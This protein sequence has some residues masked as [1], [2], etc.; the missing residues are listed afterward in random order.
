MTT[1]TCPQ[2]SMNSVA[3]LRAAL[4]RLSQAG[5]DGRMLRRRS[6]LR[7]LEAA[8]SVTSRRSRTAH[9]QPPARRQQRRP[10]DHLADAR[11]AR[12][13]Q[14]ARRR[15][16]GARAGA[17]RAALRASAPSAHRAGRRD[18]A[19]RARG[20]DRGRVRAA[21]RASPRDER[22]VWMPSRRRLEWPNGAVAQAFSAEDPE[23]LRGPQF[24]AAWC[25]ELAKWRHAE[26]TFDMLQF[27]LR[28][29][30]RPRQVITTTPRP[31]ALIKRLIADPRTRG[32]ARGDARRTPRISRRRSST[33]VV[34]ALCRHAARPPGARRRD[35]RG[36]RRRAVVA[37]AD[38]G[39]PRR[40]RRRRSR[41]S[42]S[43][44]DPP[45]SSRQGADACGIVAAGRAED[46]TIYVLA[47]A[48]AAGL[49]PAGWA[50]KAIAL[51]RQARGRRAGRR[52]QPGRRHGA[53]G[54]RARSTRACR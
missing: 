54:D 9:Q 23:S 52:G 14:D 10:V 41:A 53:R 22:P 32:D 3:T 25:D 13:R 39:V 18:R 11:R 33:Q 29:G 38:R 5:L 44:V 51:Y 19:R 47:D 16:M 4:T 50:A 17:R 21:A 37:R 30:A 15:R 43:A 26:A 7:R 28:L 48:T 20:D 24:D 36:P 6:E 8:R 35:H 45:A 12:R 46:G 40:A 34:G 49:S 42:W 31:I 2:T 27:G 1:T